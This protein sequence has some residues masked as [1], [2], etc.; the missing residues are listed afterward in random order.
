MKT[1]PP[2]LFVWSAEPLPADVLA[3]LERLAAADDVRRVAVMPDVHLSGDVCVG[4]AVATQR[5]LY[6][7]AVGGDI[8]C[9]MAAMRLDAAADLLADETVAGR[10]W[11]TC[12]AACRR[13][14]TGRPMLPRICR[15]SCSSAAQRAAAGEA[16]AARGPL[17][18]R[19]AGRGNHFLEFQSDADGQLWMMVHSGSRGVGQEIARHHLRIAEP[20]GRRPAAR[21][22]DAN[23]PPAEAIWPTPLGPW[24]MPSGIG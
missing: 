4:V 21:A 9:G 18:V 1:Y 2:N 16:Q 24:N 17:S 6:P 15:M 14:S 3:S 20:S 5:L 11:P 7:A 13:S 22:M 10:F 8:G 12:I 19:H 23:P